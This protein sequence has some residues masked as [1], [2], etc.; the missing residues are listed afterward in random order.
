MKPLV[1]IGYDDYPDISVEEAILRTVDPRIV[2]LGNPFAPE[3]ADTLA[4]ADALMVTTRP[5]TADVIAR[6]TSCRIISRVGTGI[7]SVDIDAA[8]KLGIWVTNVPDY[9][10]DEVSSHAISLLLS[11]ARRI[12]QL[13]ASTREGKWDYRVVPPIARLNTQTL[14]VIGFGRIGRAMAAK[15]RGVGLRVVVFDEFVAP[16]AVAATG[17]EAVTFE[18]LLEQS[19]YITLHTPLTD[20][21]RGLIDA[22]ALARM[23]PTALLINTARGGLVDEDA[24]LQALRREQIGGA[25]ID[26]LAIEPPSPDHPLLHEPRCWITPHIAWYSEAASPDMRGRAAEEVVRVLR[27]ER[28]RSSVNEPQVQAI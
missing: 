10:I 25:A 18:Q 5:V 14:G 22:A 20:G 21:T 17:A 7:D 27:G 4:Q 12:P 16:D 24:L 3:H 26:V 19:D 13:I 2:K 15:G 6:L 8:T 11:W 23:K 28:P 9:G 1:L